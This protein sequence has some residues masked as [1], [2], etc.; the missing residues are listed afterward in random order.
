MTRGVPMIRIVICILIYIKLFA[1]VS[2]EQELKKEIKKYESHCDNLYSITAEKISVAVKYDEKNQK[3]KGQD[4]IYYILTCPAGAYNYKSVLFV[5]SVEKNWIPVPL[6]TPIMNENDKIS[7][8][9]SDYSNG[10]LSFDKSKKQLT[11]FMKMRGLGDTSK[12]AIYRFSIEN[13]ILVRYEWDSS[14]DEK[15]NP[16]IVYSSQ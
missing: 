10:V 15:I 9:T 6:V 4:K 13:P 5:Q 16:I 3:E 1:E 14:T 2:P 11:S 12:K 8:W 7:G